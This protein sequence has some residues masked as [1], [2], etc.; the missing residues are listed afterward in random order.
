MVNIVVQTFIEKARREEFFGREEIVRTLSK[1]RA[2]VDSE[3]D[4][5]ASE[6]ASLAGR[7]GVTNFSPREGLG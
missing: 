2:A 1:E 3:L 6:L 5:K 4:R 7:L